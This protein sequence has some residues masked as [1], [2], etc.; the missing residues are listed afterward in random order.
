MNVV[1]AVEHHV[2]RLRLVADR[3]AGGRVVAVAGGGGGGG[4]P[5]TYTWLAEGGH[6][7]TPHATISDKKLLN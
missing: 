6:A 5:H 4:M 1:R 3:D 2:H 7:T